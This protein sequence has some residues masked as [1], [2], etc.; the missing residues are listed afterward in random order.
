M[1]NGFNK[2]LLPAAFK[3]GAPK[4]GGTS[5]HVTK[6][7]ATHKRK[8]KA[9]PRAAPYPPSHTP[10]HASPSAACHVHF[11]VHPVASNVCNQTYQ[12]NQQHG[13][14]L[15]I[16]CLLLAIIMPSHSTSADCDIRMHSA[17]FPYA[18]IVCDLHMHEESKGF[19]HV[20]VHGELIFF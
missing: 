11:H 18:C 7:V 3:H 16:L 12:N 14:F 9:F 10:S 19:S 8:S 6:W 13:S 20:V 4:H 17:L 2:S 1:S 15:Y 5:M